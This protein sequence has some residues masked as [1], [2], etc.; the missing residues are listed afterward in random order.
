[1]YNVKYCSQNNSTNETECVYYCDANC[2]SGIVMSFVF[3]IWF[4]YICSMCV[5]GTNKRNI[6]YL[7]SLNDNDEDNLMESGNLVVI[8]QN[9][10]KPPEY[11]E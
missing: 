6:L 5:R 11:N 4:C 8:G 1:M 2:F 7:T 3:F 10:E 9:I